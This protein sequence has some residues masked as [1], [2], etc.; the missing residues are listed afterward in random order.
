[1]SAPPV[2]AAAAAGAGTAGAALGA[3][4]CA[5]GAAAAAPVTPVERVR[6]RLPSDTLSP[7]LTLSS[8]TTPSTG[9][10]TSIVAL[11]D[12]SETSGSSALIVSPALTNTSITG[13]SLKSPI[14]GTFTSTVVAMA[15]PLSDQHAA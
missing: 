13:T 5:G 9:E 11:S 4:P 3:A 14:S 7:T 15:G 12:S 6:M 8:F 2:Y 10:G 1:M